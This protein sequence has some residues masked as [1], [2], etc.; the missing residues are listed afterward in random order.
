MLALASAS[1]S[2]TVRELSNVQDAIMLN[3]KEEVS[4]VLLFD[5]ARDRTICRH[6]VDL[7]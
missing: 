4:V 5:E 7:K 2:D 1:S 6:L 3:K